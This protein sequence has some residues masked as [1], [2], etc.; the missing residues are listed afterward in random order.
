MTDIILHHYAVSPFAEKV[1]TI[2]GYKQL[3]WR[4]V[5]IPTVMPKPDLTALT[6]GYR[7]TPVMQIG[8]DV[9]CDTPLIVRVLDSMFPER[10]VFHPS[11]AGIGMPAGRWFDRELFLSVIA[12]LFDPDVAHASAETL[13]GPEAA[14]AFVADRLP[15]MQGAPVRPPRGEDGRV[16]VEQTLQQLEAQ[17]QNSGAFLFGAVVGW[18]DFCAYH[19]LWAMRQNRALA[20]RLEAYPQVLSWFDRI[21]AFGHGQGTP[22]ASSE[23]LAVARTSQPRVRTPVES[24]LERFNLGDNVEIAAADYGREP[25]AGRLVHVAPDELCIERADERAG[26]VVVHFPRIGFRLKPQA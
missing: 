10:P 11:Q 12:Q 1:R 22:L 5:D 20:S 3:A 2:L 8:C 9:Y 19:P 23:A 14:A 21:R 24:R 17:L 4:S 6:G 7:K 16:I 26:R 18:A 25:S 15:M 13:G